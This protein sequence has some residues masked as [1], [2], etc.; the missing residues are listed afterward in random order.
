MDDPYKEVFEA[1]S[2][3]L[4]KLSNMIVWIAKRTLSVK[5]YEEFADEFS[6]KTETKEAPDS[7]K[8]KAGKKW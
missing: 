7:I 4:Q 3:T 8:Q 5:E 1:I 6:N 2:K